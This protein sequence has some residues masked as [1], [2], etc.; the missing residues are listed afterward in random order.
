MLGKNIDDNV[1]KS[2]IILSLIM[3]TSLFTYETVSLSQYF[4][5]AIFLMAAEELYLILQTK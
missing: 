1:D 4:S 2:L 5:L 3:I